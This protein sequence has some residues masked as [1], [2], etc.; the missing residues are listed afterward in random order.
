MEVGLSQ[1]E[2]L[3]H[4]GTSTVNTDPFQL[5]YLSH[6]HLLSFLSYFLSFLF[7]VLTGDSVLF[8]E[9]GGRGPSENVHR[10]CRQLI[11]SAHLLR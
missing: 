9:W 3:P 8:E 10:G 4:P 7:C 6:C 11:Q 5:S 2:Y 1:H